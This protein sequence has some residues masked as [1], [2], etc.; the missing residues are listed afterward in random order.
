MQLLGILEKNTAPNQRAPLREIC[1]CLTAKFRLKQP[2]LPLKCAV[3]VVFYNYL[4]VTF[5]VLKTLCIPGRSLLHLWNSQTKLL[6]LFHGKITISAEELLWFRLPLVPLG[7]GVGQLQVLG[8][9]GTGKTGN[10]KVHF[11]RQEKHKEFAKKY[12]YIRNIFYT[13][14]L[15]PTQRKF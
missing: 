2:S 14:N 4:G 1:S 5:T 10:L 11:S 3:S 7:D 15:T 13:G 8:C 9:H 6:S 12:I